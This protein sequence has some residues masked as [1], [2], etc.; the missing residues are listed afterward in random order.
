MSIR[1][2]L[3]D[4]HQI[5]RDALRSMIAREHDLEVVGEASDGLE[6]IQVTRRLKPDVVVLD[7]GMQ[8]MSGIEVTRTLAGSEG[9]PKLLGLSAS[10]ERRMIMQMLDAG[11]SGYVVKSAGRD[12]LLRAIRAV[13]A[14]RTYLCPEA[15]AE[16]VDSVR[17]ARN[18]PQRPSEGL[19]ARER[20]VLALLSDG[21][22]SA[23]IAQRLCI[24]TSTVEV[25]RRNIMRKLELHSIAE[26]TKY[27]VRNGL[28][29]A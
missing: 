15:S 17:Y 1:I 28:T 10:A 26:L 6:G 27:A 21:H 12:E 25:H 16:L 5:L 7:V 9:G 24:A 4:D 29:Q 11:V 18:G 13:A 20:E 19:A 14:G 3:V 22:T 23:Q 2:V 8:K